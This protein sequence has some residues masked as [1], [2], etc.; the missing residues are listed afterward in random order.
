[1]ITVVTTFCSAR[2]HLTNTERSEQQL[3]V[4]LVRS[5]VRLEQSWLHLRLQR[6]WSVQCGILGRGQPPG[7][8]ARRG[9]HLRPDRHQEGRQQGHR[10]RGEEESY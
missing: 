1:M 9:R 8:L 2:H 7:V 4:C 6:Q 5:R 10:V 3:T